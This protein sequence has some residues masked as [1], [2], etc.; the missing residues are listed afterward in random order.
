MAG[1]S[2][3]FGDRLEAGERLARL[4]E[5]YHAESPVVYALPRGGVP[6]GFGISHSLGAPLEVI[7]SRKLGAPG[8]PELGIGAVTSD[9]VRFLNRPLVEHLG[10]P[11]EYVERVTEEE[12]EEASRRARL[13]RGDRPEPEVGGRTAIVVDDGLATG[14]T[15]RAAME[16][17]SRRG[18][19]RIVVAV[20]VCAAQTLRELRSEG[21]E[22]VC[23]ESPENLGAIGFW[24][25]DFSQVTDEE[26]SEL[27]ERAR[28]R[29]GQTGREPPDAA[30]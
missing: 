16:S 3:I 1:A 28:R 25:Q 11:E 9:G 5:G 8:Q 2:N 27:L 7:V 19:S 14:A 24:Y 4:L 29:R 22:V 26:A 6:V 20:P 12:S 13:L 10:V 15:A 21:Y 17:L 23:L 30:I 18:A